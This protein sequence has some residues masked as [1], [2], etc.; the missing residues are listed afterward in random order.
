MVVIF[1]VVKVRVA[2]HVEVGTRVIESQPK[3]V[4]EAATVAAAR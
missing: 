2:F 3:F 4:R 1:S